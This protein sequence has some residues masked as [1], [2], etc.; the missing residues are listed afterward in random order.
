MTLGLAGRVLRLV[1]RVLRLVGTALSLVGKDFILDVMA[2]RQI[3][4]ALSLVGR[5][6]RLAWGADIGLYSPETGGESHVH[7]GEGQVIG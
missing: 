6:L 3:V 1:K 5:V 4:K 7:S 2:M